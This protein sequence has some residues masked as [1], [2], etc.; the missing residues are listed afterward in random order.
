MRLLQ[1]TTSTGEIGLTPKFPD[2]SIP[3]Y[4]I[5]SHTWGDDEVLFKDLTDGT[6]NKKAG[7]DKIR[8]VETKPGVM[9]CSSAG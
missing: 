8:S 4:A 3:P 6:G 2:D 1:H 5:L 9:A 7:Y